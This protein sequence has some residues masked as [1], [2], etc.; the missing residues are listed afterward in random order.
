MSDW[1]HLTRTDQNGFQIAI[2]NIYNAGVEIVKG[3][4]SGWNCTYRRGIK[5]TGYIG[6]IFGS[7]GGE[8]DFG[9]G[10]LSQGKRVEGAGLNLGLATVELNRRQYFGSRAMVR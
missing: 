3:I 5:P 9:F 2:D 7:L 4:I 10:S 1:E 6:D 8:P